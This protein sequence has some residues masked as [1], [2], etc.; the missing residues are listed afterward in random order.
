MADDLDRELGE[1]LR[2]TAAQWRPANPL[3]DTR[4]LL[5]ERIARRRRRQ[6]VA[7]AGVV[8]AALLV[9]TLTAAVPGRGRTPSVNLAGPTGSTSSAAGRVGTRPGSHGSTGCPVACQPPPSTGPRGNVTG[10]PT[11]TRPRTGRTATTAPAEPT[12]PVVTTSPPGTTVPS[13]VVT[14]VPS[15]TTPTTTPPGAVY[16]FTEA[17]N[18]RTVQVNT[19]D[20]IVL[21]LNQCGGTQWSEPQSSDTNVMAWMNGSVDPSAGTASAKFSAVSS[22]QAQLTAHIRRSPCAPP[23]AAFV[24]TVQVVGCAGQACAPDTSPSAKA[25]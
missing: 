17:D 2:T 18:G 1:I 9:V 21:D 7:G 15:T 13:T 22:G 16:T 20:R 19:Q 12:V 14:T 23:V 25:T 6:M 8:A 5:P 24:L 3:D 4:R 10:V 11:P